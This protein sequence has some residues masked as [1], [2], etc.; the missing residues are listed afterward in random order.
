MTAEDKSAINFGYDIRREGEADMFKKL[1]QMK[2]KKKLNF[3]YKIVIGFMIVS[4]IFSMAGMGILYSNLNNYVNGSQRADTAVKMCIIDV[5]IAARNI[6]EM[7]LSGDEKAYEGYRSTTEKEL[8]EI[9][10][11]LETLKGTGMIEDELYKQYEEALTAWG[12]VGYE[13]MDKIEEGDNEAAREQ[14]M[15]ECVPALDKVLEISTDI[16]E[17][18]DGLKE[19]AINTSRIMT[20]VCIALVVVFIA[21]AAILATRI[22][23]YI[24]NSIVEPLRQIKNVASELSEGNLHSHLEYTSVDEMGDLAESLRNSISTLSSYVDDIGRAMKQFS[25]GNFD[26]QPQVEWKGDFIGILDS[27]MDFERSMADTVKGI[28]RVADQVAD[29]AEMVSASSTDLAQGATDQ[30]GVTEELTATVENVS[31]QVAENAESA[32]A[33]SR[34]V[35]N[36]GVEIINGNEKMQQMVESMNDIDESSKEISKI[37]STINDIASQTNLLALNASIEAARAGEAGKGFAVVADQVSVLAEQSAKAAKESTL[38]IESSV[39]AVEKGIVIADE[40]AKQLQNV[41][42]GSREIT[43]KVNKVADVLEHQAES[44]NQINEGIEHINDVVQTNSASSEECAAASQE[45]REQ[46]TT[47]EGL[48]RKFKVAKFK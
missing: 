26:V 15:E 28:Q 30:A 39:R 21:G 9:G 7:A 6:R 43:E 24:V 8:N 2:L 19:D 31:E 41:V 42:E 25:S 14:I 37:I 22:G 27:F 33:I 13:I 16:D 20:V 44:I 40:T 38:L 34:D 47:L 17:V 1:A 48:I 18:T 29:A 36:V 4:G 5:N 3:G 10:N 12:E 35:E 32:K 11:E 46:A 45:M 23:R